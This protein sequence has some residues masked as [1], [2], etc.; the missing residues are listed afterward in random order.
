MSSFMKALIALGV[1]LPLAAFV[2]GSLVSASVE[3]PSRERIIIE[4]DSMPTDQEIKDP[5]RKQD[6]GRKSPA[7]DAEDGVDDDGPD[8]DTD[9]GGRA[10]RT[11]DGGRAPGGGGGD[12]DDDDERD[13][14]STTGGGGG[15]DDDTDSDDSGED[16]D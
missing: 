15:G 10:E 11:D 8:D 4:D 14:D 12:A 16:D 9:D 6:E 3:S 13:D 1:A 2:V 7:D 5:R